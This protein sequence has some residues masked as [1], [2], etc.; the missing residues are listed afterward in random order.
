MAAE[1]IEQLKKTYC[2][3][4][5]VQFMHIDNPEVKNWLYT[6]MEATQ[7]RRRMSRDEQLRIFRKLTDAETFEDFIHKKYLGAKRF[8]LEGGETLIPLMDMALDGL[9][10]HGVRHAVIGMAH[11]GRLNVMT[12]IMG[13]SRQKSLKS[14]KMVT[15]L[16]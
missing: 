16:R 13:K 15:R 8:S 9:A 1:P 11:R 12:N 5:G 2:G 6:R 7:N 3:S 14:S 4:V 10:R